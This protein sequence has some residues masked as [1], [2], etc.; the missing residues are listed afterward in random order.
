MRTLLH[1]IFYTNFYHH[2]HLQSRLD[3]CIVLQVANR[4]GVLYPHKN[5]NYM[6]MVCLAGWNNLA[7]ITKPDYKILKKCSHS[8]LSTN[9][10]MYNHDMT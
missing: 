4:L 7:L 6:A 8:H 2:Y 9:Y 3:V 10:T 1:L 5:G